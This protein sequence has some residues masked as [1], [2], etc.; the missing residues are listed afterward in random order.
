MR[1]TTQLHTTG[2]MAV[3]NAIKDYNASLPLG[4]AAGSPY[5]LLASRV[6]GCG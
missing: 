5:S 4:G 1:Y 6:A 3:I 2:G